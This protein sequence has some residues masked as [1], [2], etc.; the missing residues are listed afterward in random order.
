MRVWIDCTNSPHVNFFA[1]MIR[2]LMRDGHEVTITCR[3]LAN[4]VDLLK[5]QGFDYR[6]VGRHYGANAIKKALGYPVRVSQLAAF[7]RGKRIDVA[8]GHS[9]FELPA[10]SRLLGVRSIY[11]ND[12]EYAVANRVAFPCATTIMIPEFLSLDKVRRQWANPRKVV[13]YPGVKEAIYLFRLETAC[14]DACERRS[15]GK[16][17]IRPEPSTAQ[18]YS[19]GVNFMDDLIGKLKERYAVVV[20]PRDQRQAEHYRQDR[21]DGVVIP[22]RPLSLEAVIAECSLFIGA[23]GTMTREAAVVGIPTISTYQDELLDVDRYLIARGRMVHERRLTADRVVELMESARERGPSTELLEKGRE[24]YR[25]ILS[26]VL[27]GG[28]AVPHGG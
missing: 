1:G 25:L 12:N 17:F 5:L 22:A 3:P 8:I 2:D 20:M 13:R 23:G 18:Y 28:A 16:I 21:F 9:S 11:L 7:L 26:H 15:P 14:R 4:T 27:N 10:V 6:V 19:G 24:A